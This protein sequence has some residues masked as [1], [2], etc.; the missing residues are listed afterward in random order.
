MAHSDDLRL[1]DSI[2]LLVFGTLVLGLN[3]WATWTFDMM[4]KVWVVP[5]SFNI[6]G[7]VILTGGAMSVYQIWRRRRSGA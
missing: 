5:L 4:H 2:R 1:K 7:F 3:T 6:I